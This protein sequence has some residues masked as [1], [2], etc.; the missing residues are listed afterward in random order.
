MA[1]ETTPS[2]VLTLEMETNPSIISR[3]ESDLEVSRVIYNSC[4][5]E[6]VKREKQMKRTK[7]YKKIRRCLRAVSKKLSYYETQENK[8]KMT[9]YQ[10]EKNQLISE[11]FDIQKQFHLSEYSMHEYLK[12]I[13]KHFGDTLNADIAQKIA[14]RAWNTVK[15]KLKGEAKNVKFLKRREMV[16]FEGK[17]NSTGWF[18]RT[19]QIIFGESK[20]DVKIKENDGY[21]QEALSAIES[22]LEFEYKTKKGER[23]NVSHKVKYVRVL[24]RVIRGNVRYYAQLTV[25]GFPPVKRKKDGSFKHQLGT[26]RV[27]GDLGTSSIAVVGENEVLLTNLAENVM[28]QSRRIRLIQRKMDHSKRAMNPNYFNENGTIKK[29]KKTWIFSKRYMKLKSELKELHRKQADSR[30]QSH[31]ILSNKLLTLGDEHY[32]E[33]MNIKGLQ[34][35]SKNT[36]MSEKTGKFKRKKRFG[37]SI[38]HRAPAMFLSILE[39]KVKTNGGTFKKVNTQTFKA[40]QYDHKENNYKKKELKERW[41]IFDD[42]TKIQRDLY[43]AFLLQNSNKVGT[44]ANKRLCEK[45]FEAFKTLHDKE[46]EQIEKQET[47]VLNSG[48]RLKSKKA[49]VA[50]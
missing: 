21:I 28:N 38:G 41:H 16:S 35:R 46:I 37:K 47:F 6:L 9:F 45:T 17:K 15:K 24:K 7:K 31:N 4:L 3:I 13:R 2:F 40:S 23:K 48:I 33:E 14:T 44:K 8:E 27:G 50:T 43:S 18:Y 26:G 22:N 29:G 12:P 10:A 20:I 42:G 19:K 11:L 49:I 30:K 32:W 5:G 25:Q 39:R 34:K 36:E 1:K